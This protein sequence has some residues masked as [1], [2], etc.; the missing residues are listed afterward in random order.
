MAIR[1][2]CEHAFAAVIPGYGGRSAWTP[3]P[4]ESGPA[5]A[6]SNPGQG[7]YAAK[8]AI[9]P[10]CA[11]ES[12][13]MNI[14]LYGRF[15]TDQQSES[16]A[17]DQLLIGREHAARLAW[18]IVGE[19]KDE[20][21]S[22]AALGNRPGV[23]ALLRD[24]RL[25]EI[26]IV[27]DLSRLSR[28]Q[29]LA[30]M[31]ARLR[32]RGVR[33]I[34]VQDGFDSESRTARMQA[35][36]SGIMSEEFRSMVADR[37]RSA[38]E[39]RARA[40]Q[41]TGG[42]AYQNAAIV[43]EIFSRFADGESMKAIANDLNRRAVPSPG[44]AWKPRARPRGNWL[45]ST[46]H[47]IL[48]NERYAGRLV[49][50]KSQWVKDPDSGKRMRRERPESEWVV[51][52]CDRM[53]DDATWKRVQGRFSVRPGRGGAPRWLLSGILECA[54]CSGKMIVMG[55][56]QSR[57]ICGTNH[58]GGEHACA[59]GSTFPREVAERHILEP[60]IHDLLSPAAIAEG[61]RVMREERVSPPKPE[62]TDR[63][64]IELERLV[65][66]GILSAETAAPAIA[67]ARKTAE[68]KRAAEPLPAMPWP[69]EKAWRQAVVA[70][71]EVLR[72]DD[73][74]AA[75]EALRHLIGPARC[76]QA[77]DGHVLVEL[78][79]RQVLLATG[80]GSRFNQIPGRG[81]VY[82]SVACPR[83]QS[84]YVS[85]P[86]STE[87]KERGVLDAAKV[88]HIRT[89]G[90]T[91]AGL[92]RLYGLTAPGVRD[93]RVGNTWRNHPTP[94]DKAPREGAGR[95]AGAL[96]RKRH[97]GLPRG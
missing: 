19:Y 14:R 73:V 9:S 5:R 55:G 43:Q 61:I 67:Q 80:T 18:N 44:A 52:T 12:R 48:H 27:T 95:K 24:L 83:Y 36:L 21:I 34:G 90:L 94:P 10:A 78:T 8:V 84:I 62:P 89:S 68:A 50:N 16:S 91:D 33:V 96:A 37:T 66:M 42:K 54:L 72:G 47:A 57:Y 38:L 15:S 81:S 49:W 56:E 17:D 58:A 63:E 71:R 97:R 82:E 6:D 70:I 60:V 75:R 65:K 45:V 30:P 31:L 7:R 29:D 3:R 4:Y 11:T 92:A 35:G 87:S 79:T 13:A 59:N 41:A 53:I 88:H 85:V 76:Q 1:G 26:L 46:L 23:Q 74:V 40:G 77:K 32:H 39:L 86:I 28:S 69:S 2:A 20:G 93:A 25:G 22:G 51:Q 64:Q